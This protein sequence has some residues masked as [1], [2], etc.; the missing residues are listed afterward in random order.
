MRKALKID[1]SI[2]LKKLRV[3]TNKLVTSKIVGSY[4]SV[5]KGRGLEFLDYRHYT[6]DDD[7]A[8]IDWKASV[9]SK[10][11]LVK[12]FAEERNLNVFFLVDVSSSMIYSSI[13][14]LK[15][16]Y[17]IELIATLS[18]SVL[19][20]SDSV[21]LAMF[22]DKIVLNEKPS[23]GINTYMKLMKILIDTR[24]YG[25][26]YDLA[27][28]IKFTMPL[29]KES[30]IVIIVSDFIGLKNDWKHYLKVLGKKADLIGIMISDPNDLR[31]PDYH[32][33]VILGDALSSRQILVD[34][35]AVREDYAKYVELRD[36]EIHEAF[37]DSKADFLHLRTD[38]PFIKPITDLF[39]RRAK[40]A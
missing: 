9:R 5:F 40:K 27:E 32:G 8:T 1:E 11:L 16:E 4:R 39:L 29:L 24:H 25:G 10:E 14:K 7:A 26:N 22:T 2:G 38:E 30:S 3:L 33:Q 34:V 36:R 19:Q 28:A 12:E 20:A 37:A 31:M 18:Y 23:S 17:A 21:S 6:P 15:I 35:D 13:D